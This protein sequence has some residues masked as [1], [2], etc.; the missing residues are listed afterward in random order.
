MANKS[1]GSIY[2]QLKKDH[3]AVKKLLKQMIDSK[4]SN[5]DRRR[6]LLQELKADLLAHAHA[7]EKLL[8][9]ALERYSQTRDLAIEA[10]EEHHVVE[11]MVGE[12]ERCEPSDAHWK[13]KV[14]VLQE[15]LEHHIAEEEKELFAKARKVL[16]TDMEQQIGR[17]FQQQKRQE[18]RTL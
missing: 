2:D 10:E 8:Y 13:A 3:E 16:D 15:V 5:V 14:L 17:R 9:S 4:E 1:R 11:L 12:L 6:T 18:M 7:E